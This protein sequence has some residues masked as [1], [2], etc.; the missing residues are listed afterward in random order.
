MAREDE[1]GHSLGPD[2]EYDLEDDEDEYPHLFQSIRSSTGLEVGVRVTWP[3]TEPI[4]LSTCLPSDEIA[5]M[6]HGT[7]WYVSSTSSSVFSRAGPCFL[8]LTLQC[9]ESQ[10]GWHTCVEGS[11]CG[12]AVFT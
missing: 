7:Q 4:E 6:F 9:H 3:D 12:A 8:N 11:Y 5:P 10:Q 2:G 1:K